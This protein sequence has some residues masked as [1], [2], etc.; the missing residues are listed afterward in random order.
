MLRES[1]KLIL[2]LALIIFAVSQTGSPSSA[3]EFAGGLLEVFFGPQ[4]YEATDDLE[5]EL[6]NFIDQAEESLDISV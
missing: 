4:E 6:V 3:E 2:G 5:T 1:T